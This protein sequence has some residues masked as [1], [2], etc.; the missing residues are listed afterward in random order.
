MTKAGKMGAVA[1][2]L[3]LFVGTYCSS[4]DADADV[5]DAATAAS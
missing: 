2:A 4:P 3:M 5:E 1:A